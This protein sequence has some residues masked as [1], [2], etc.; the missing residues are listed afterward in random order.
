VVGLTLTCIGEAVISV[1]SVIHKSFSSKERGFFELRG[2]LRD[3][4][5]PRKGI[6]DASSRRIF[7]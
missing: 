6:D 1:N 5:F 2:L 3:D 7:E 4:D